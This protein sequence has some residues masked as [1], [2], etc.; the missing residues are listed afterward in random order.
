MALKQPGLPSTPFFHWSHCIGSCFN[1][2]YWLN[3]SLAALEEC[4]CDIQLPLPL[5]QR[6]GQH[7]VR[8]ENWGPSLFQEQWFHY[9]STKGGVCL[10]SEKNRTNNWFLPIFCCSSFPPVWGSWTVSHNRGNET[11]TSNQATF[12]RMCKWDRIYA[13]QLP[14]LMMAVVHNHS[15]FLILSFRRHGT[16]SLLS[17]Q[18]TLHIWWNNMSKRVKCV[19][20]KKISILC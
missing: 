8:Q 18:N 17:F 14:V 3:Q 6:V 11:L 5:T 19:A 4:W 10:L 7:R 13:F 20:A 2:Y 1:S 12:L 15:A 16:P 9:S